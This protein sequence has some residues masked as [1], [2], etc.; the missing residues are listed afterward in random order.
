MRVILYKY[1]S[2]INIIK[3]LIL[4]TA[5]LKIDGVR[6]DVGYALHINK[7]EDFNLVLIWIYHINVL[8][9]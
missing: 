7:Y 4:L 3:G 8:Y 9:I 1:S 6:E 2:T 5:N